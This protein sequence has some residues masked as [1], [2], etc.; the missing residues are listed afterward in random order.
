MQVYLSIMRYARAFKTLQKIHF[1]CCAY[2]K[3]IIVYIVSLNSSCLGRVER[4]QNLF[5]KGVQYIMYLC[6]ICIVYTLKKDIVKY[7]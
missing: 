7:V 4:T 6:I 3:I 1:H 2:R 5:I